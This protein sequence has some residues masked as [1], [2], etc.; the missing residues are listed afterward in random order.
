M[1]VTLK[2]S[3]KDLIISFATKGAVAAG[4]EGNKL[5]ALNDLIQRKGVEITSSTDTSLIGLK[6]LELDK[7]NAIA[8]KI[9]SY[10]K[11]S[12]FPCMIKVYLL[13]VN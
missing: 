13:S 1:S 12:F 7:D 6:M 11:G 4:M 10:N 3:A 8:L 9:V 2:Q 5:I